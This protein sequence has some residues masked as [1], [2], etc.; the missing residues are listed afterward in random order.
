[1]I[2]ISD[3]ALN[4]AQEIIFIVEAKIVRHSFQLNKDELYEGKK[5]DTD[6]EEQNEVKS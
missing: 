6:E 5:N 1:M 3:L 2:F 4:I